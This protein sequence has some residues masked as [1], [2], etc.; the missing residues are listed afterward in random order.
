MQTN[1]KEWNN[2]KSSEQ[3]KW[4]SKN[5]KETKTNDQ[6]ILSCDMCDSVGKSKSGLLK[7]TKN[8]HG[9]KKVQG[10]SATKEIESDKFTNRVND[11]LKSVDHLNNSENNYSCDVI[12]TL[13]QR[14]S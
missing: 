8:K 11:F 9:T 5:C 6:N 4:R 10:C 7:H 12:K 1:K 14:S 2:S 13:H 3:G